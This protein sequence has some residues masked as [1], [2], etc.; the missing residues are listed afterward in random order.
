MRT[1]THAVSSARQE[2]IPIAP[3]AALHVAALFFPFYAFGP[4]LKDGH[5]ASF[6]TLRYGLNGSTK[7]G[8]S[9]LDALRPVLA[10]TRAYAATT[11][12]PSPAPITSAARFTPGIAAPII[13]S[14]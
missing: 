9:S 10:A 5:A 4:G 11:L 12:A 6:A 8:T 1:S 7:E 3:Q 2:P 14:A 13:R